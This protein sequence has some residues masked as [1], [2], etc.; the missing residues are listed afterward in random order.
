MAKQAELK[1][2]ERPK[3]ADIEV[4]A[5]DY[6]RLTDLIK[7]RSEEKKQAMERLVAAMR[8]AKL[9]KYKYDDR[10]ITLLEVDKIKVAELNGDGDED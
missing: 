4:A 5:D 3:I 9:D 1:G 7:A 8:R 6:V 10:V 2:V